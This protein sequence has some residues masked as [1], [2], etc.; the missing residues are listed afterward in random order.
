MYELGF[1]RE[2]GVSDTDSEQT[3]QNIRFTNTLAAI[4]LVF[5]SL[6]L[7]LVLFQYGFKSAAKFVSVSLLISCVVFI[8]NKR[9]MPILARYWLSYTLPIAIMIMSVVIKFTNPDGYTGHY[10]Y[11]DL[12]MLILISGIIP[13]LIFPRNPLKHILV[14]LLPSAILLILF[15]PIHYLFNVGYED[16]FIDPKNGLYISGILF[17][18]AYLFVVLSML[19]VKKMNEKL[20]ESN[21]ELIEELNKKNKTQETILLRKQNLLIQNREVNDRL[22]KKQEEIL[23]SKKDLELASKLIKEQKSKLE[24]I[25]IE[26]NSKVEERTR[27]LKK[28][29]DELLVQNN[30]LLQFSNTVSHNL[31]APVAS[32]LGLVHLFEIEK[33]EAHKKELLSHIKSSSI[34]LDT[35]ISDLNKVVDMRN[36]LFHLKE[37]IE[38]KDE[39]IKVE[40]LLKIG[41]DEFGAVLN[42]KLNVSNIYFIRSYI[43]S[44]LYNLISNA[45]KYS[46]PNKK[47]VITILSY[48]DSKS[49]Y[50][51]VEDVGLG[52]DLVKF[53]NDIFKMHKRFHTHVDG[54]GMGLYLVKQQVE[55][56]N[57]TISVK[58]ELDK[59]TS[60][61]ME[62]PIPKKIRFQEYYKNSFATIAYNANLFA[63]IL[64]WHKP[65]DTQKYKEILSASKEMFTNYNAN[66][67]LIDVRNLGLV[68]EEDRNWFSLKVFGAIISRGCKTIALVKGEEDGKD[69]SY[70]QKMFD[71]ANSKGVVFNMFFDYDQAIEFFQDQVSTNQIKIDA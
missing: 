48:G 67:W 28:L 15:D 36:Q 47:S 57:G 13:L 50:I 35:V 69:F 64:I 1:I 6:I 30:G 70:W 14:A 31:R 60:F 27:S 4:L 49:I 5:L 43:H 3:K 23:K 68:S 25:N 11:F 42:V 21:D 19:S 32:L 20:I 24:F 10:E 55:A 41:L 44:I 18:T 26:L 45:I 54:K 52:I 65:P 34:A 56:M 46:K 63:S 37:N 16:L 7:L 51:E 38:L 53:G 12:R 61:V 39:I 8:L 17:D 66:K 22:L 71:I 58:S 33:E 9:G 62:F 2:I 40:Q 59:G 29:N